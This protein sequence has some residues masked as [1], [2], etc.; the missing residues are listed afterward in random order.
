MEQLEH[1]TETLRPSV[2][3]EPGE[4]VRV[5]DGPFNDFS[6]VVEEV[7]YEKNKVRVAVLIFGRSTGV[8]L[9]FS[10]V[11]NDLINQPIIDY[12]VDHDF[13]TAQFCNCMI[14]QRISIAT[15]LILQ[16]HN[17]ATTENVKKGRHC[18]IVPLQNYYQ[19][20]IH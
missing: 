15:A 1:G 3:F 8:E 20:G 11:E 4:M 7:N 19:Q 13:A 9:E 18:K 5:I 10:Q 17:S 16:R 12:L 14:L 6:G 2:N